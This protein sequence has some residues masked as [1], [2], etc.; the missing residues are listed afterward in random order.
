MKMKSRLHQILPALLIALL[1][2]FALTPAQAQDEIKVTV[3]NYVRAETDVQIKGY[4][5]TMDAF[6]RFSHNRKHY[7]VDNQVTVRGARD[8]VYSFGAF[9]L[10][11]PLT[12]T[13]PDPEGRFQSMMLISQDHSIP[14][15]IYGPT[16]KTFMLSLIHI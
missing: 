4:S 14:P 2:I 11:S 1:S 3:D 8:F 6:G 10:T 15:A 5:E 16:K 9:D 13:M 7:D 12:I